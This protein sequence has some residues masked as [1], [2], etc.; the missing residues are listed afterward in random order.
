MN[1][2]HESDQLHI[3]YS[4]YA[5]DARQLRSEAIRSFFSSADITGYLKKLLGLGN[6]VPQKMAGQQIERTGCTA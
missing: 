5:Q 6:S 3:D 2:N 1:Q 4:R